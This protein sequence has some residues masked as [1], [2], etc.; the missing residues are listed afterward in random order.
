MD[1]LFPCKD[2]VE[3]LN[4]CGIK[5]T[6]IFP[7]FV[8]GGA[9][10][11]SELCERLQKYSA[12]DEYQFI[13]A[14]WDK[15]DSYMHTYGPDSSNCDDYLLHINKQIED[16]VSKLSLDTMLIVLAD[17][18]QITVDKTINLYQTKYRKYFSLKPSL[19]FRTVAFFIDEQYK[20][21][22][23]KE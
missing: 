13:Y 2:I 10:S 9:H 15:Y 11:F 14:Y 20:S 3:E 17:H 7:D 22:F 18:G 16:L 21:L 12:N 6:K 19:E 23:E 1:N 4:D 8:L 5:A